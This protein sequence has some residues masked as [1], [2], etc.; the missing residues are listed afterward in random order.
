[1]TARFTVD[2][3][4]V[5]EDS[6]RTAEDFLGQRYDVGDL[7][8][9]ATTAGRSAVLKLGRVHTIDPFPVTRYDRDTREYVKGFGYRVGL[10]WIDTARGWSSPS[11]R[12]NG[13]PR[14]SYPSYENIIKVERP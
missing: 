9:Y 1:M 14:L 2:S 3:A 11:P 13:K 6:Y 8:V 10:E 4:G 5:A 7:V 12:T